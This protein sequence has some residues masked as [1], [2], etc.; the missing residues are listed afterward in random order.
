MAWRSNSSF[1]PT[2]CWVVQSPYARLI[3][4]VP[5]LAISSSNSVVCLAGV[6]SESMSTAS[7]MV[8]AEFTGASLRTSARGQTSHGVICFL[9]SDL[10]S[11]QTARFWPFRHITTWPGAEV[12]RRLATNQV[13]LV[14]N[15]VVRGLTPRAI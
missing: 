11:N 6:L 12:R 13:G 4:G 15:D 8:S 5:Y 2:R 7:R 9:G 10:S 3:V 1:Q 14:A